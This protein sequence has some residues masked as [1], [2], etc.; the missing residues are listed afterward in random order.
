M[1][2]LC[3]AS[4]VTLPSEVSIGTKVQKSLGLLSHRSGSYPLCPF[5]AAH[6]NAESPERIEIDL[7]SEDYLV[8]ANPVSIERSLRLPA[9]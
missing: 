4:M 1:L 2:S 6:P 9:R 7:L 3:H 5:C 8:E